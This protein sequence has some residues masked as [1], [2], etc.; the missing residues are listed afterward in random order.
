DYTGSSGLGDSD[1]ITDLQIDV[2]KNHP[3]YKLTTVADLSSLKV[4]RSTVTIIECEL[5]CT[6]GQRSTTMVLRLI[7]EDGIWKIDSQNWL[8][9]VH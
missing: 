4:K 7:K 6:V 5:E 9:G 3:P 2:T 8:A 1:D